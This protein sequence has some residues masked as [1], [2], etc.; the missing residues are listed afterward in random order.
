MPADWAPQSGF[1]IAIAV[2]TYFSL[3]VGELVPKQ[4]AL[5]AAEPLAMIAAPAMK[6][7]SRIT[8]PLVWLLDRS[9]AVLLRLLQVSHKGVHALSAEELQMIFA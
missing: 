7:L 6:L 1:I 4:I 2:T 8:A 5:R 9:S 3:V